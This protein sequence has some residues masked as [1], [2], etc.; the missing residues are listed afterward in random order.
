MPS[1]VQA[2]TFNGIKISDADMGNSWPRGA[3]LLLRQLPGLWDFGSE[4]KQTDEKQI[5]LSV[6][7]EILW[8]CGVILY[9]WDWIKEYLTNV[10]GFSTIKI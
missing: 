8:A 5:A 4:S 6:Y 1:Y 10:L 3:T 2:R 7:L 9:C